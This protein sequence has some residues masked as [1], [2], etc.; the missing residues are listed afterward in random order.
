MKPTEIIGNCHLW[1]G[2][3]IEILPHLPK[4][5]LVL[6]DPPYFAVKDDEW[7]NQWKSESEF[8]EWCGVV[9]VFIKNVLTCNGSL[10]WFCS[11][12]MAAQVEVKLRENFNVLNNIVWDKGAGRKGTAG[13]GIDVT[14]L[15][16]FW[17]ANTERLIFAE[18]K[19]TDDAANDASGY[20]EAVCSAK[21]GIFGEYL[22]QNFASAGV[23]NKKIAELFP[24]RTGG[25]TGCV[26]NWLLGNNIPTK[27]QYETIRS[28]LGDGFLVKKYEEMRQQYEEMRRP[29]FAKSDMEWGDVWKFSIERFQQHPTQ[30]PISLIEHIVLVSTRDN[31]SVADPFMGSGTT[32]VACANMGKTFYGIER[33]PKYF[34]IACKRIEQAYAQGRLFE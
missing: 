11:P 15:R 6:T 9:S 2:D 4:V 26:S 24:S 5:D 33:E 28:F 30:K 32:G 22:K 13:S 17:S 23:T 27:E 29:F 14:A 20:G 8:I 16:K 1:L 25:L 7:D 31:S 19:G 10:Y 3:C 12:Q 18:Q 21:V 34:D